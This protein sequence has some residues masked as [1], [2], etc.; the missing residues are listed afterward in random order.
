ME[1]FTVDAPA[2]N[3]LPS[4]SQQHQHIETQEDQQQDSEVEIEAL[5]EDKLAHLHQ[6]NERLRL[7]KEHMAK[8]RAVARRSQIMQ[9]QIEQ[10]RATQAEL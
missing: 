5:I 6:Q 1:A 2:P 7:M 8:R 10:E 4:S 9:Q 3:T